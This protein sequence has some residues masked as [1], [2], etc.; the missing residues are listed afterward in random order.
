MI[1]TWV[2][3]TL[4][5]TLLYLSSRAV[6]AIGGFC[7]EGGAYEIETHC[8]DNVVAF[9]P[10]SVYGGL[11]AV[12]LR[13]FVARGLG[14]ALE[15]IAWPILF[16]GLS[17]AFF[18]SGFDPR[19]MGVP[20]IVMGAMFFVMGA[21]P[22]VPWLRQSGN[23]SALLAGTSTLNGTTV[24]SVSFGLPRGPE[25]NPWPLARLD[26]AVLIPLSLLAA[27]AGVWIGMLWFGAA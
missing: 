3:F 13:I 6:M 15:L 14:A 12:G 8:P 23:F 24:G 2:G 27:G 19:Q 22:L 17:L 11:T 25:T 26:Y 10:L 18:E 20:G 16:I 7:A 1:V 9:L 21:A 5:I 4:A